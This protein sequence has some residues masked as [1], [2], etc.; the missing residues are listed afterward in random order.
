MPRTVRPMRNPWKRLIAE[1]QIGAA[2]WYASAIALL[3]YS[4]WQSRMLMTSYAVLQIVDAPR[5][6]WAPGVWEPGE[7][8]SGVSAVIA[9]A[10]VAFLVYRFVRRVPW[11]RRFRLSFLLI[12][13]AAA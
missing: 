13:A 5:G 4:P 11:P 7:I 3:L 12:N 1:R 8:Q 9:G 10:I 6:L 2:E